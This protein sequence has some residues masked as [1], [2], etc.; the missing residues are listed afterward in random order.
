MDNFVIFSLIDNLFMSSLTLVIFKSVW[1]ASYFIFSIASS[2][3]SNSHASDIVLIASLHR[4]SPCLIH[5]KTLDVVFLC[6]SIT[7]RGVLGC[8]YALISSTYLLMSNAI[9]DIPATLAL[10]S[11]SS[12]SSSIGNSATM[13]LMDSTSASLVSSC[14]LKYCSFYCRRALH[15]FSFLVSFYA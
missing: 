8:C 1:H 4:F 7:S 12:F 3:R 14:T 11:Y 9:L 6:S 5:S 10:S 15:S 2:S 13:H